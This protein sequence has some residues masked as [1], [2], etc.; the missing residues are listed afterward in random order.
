MPPRKKKTA[1][2]AAQAASKKKSSTVDLSKAHEERVRSALKGLGIGGASSAAA[3]SALVPP[4]GDVG[5]AGAQAGISAAEAIQR[6]AS[7]YQALQGQGFHSGDIEDALEQL[8]LATLSEEAALD[9][10]LLHLEPARLPRRYADQ[11]RHAAAGGAVDVKLRAERKGR[12]ADGGADGEERLA[13]ELTRAEQQRQREQDEQKREAAQQEEA[14]RRREQQEME[15][16]EKTDRRAWIMQ[17]MDNS[18][19]EEGSQAGSDQGSE[20]GSVVEDWEVWGDPREVERRRAERK[21]SQLPRDTR[22]LLIAEELTQAKDEAVRAK[23]AKDK[24]RQRALGELIRQL[25][26]EMDQLGITE[27]D[28]PT[29]PQQNT[30]ALAPGAAVP[31]QG[32]NDGQHEDGA[33]QDWQAG[34]AAGEA[35]AGSEAPD[36]SAL[37]PPEGAKGAEVEGAAGIGSDSGSDF[38]LGLFDEDFASALEPSEAA[39]QRQRR[40]AAPA[41]A[42]PV[43]PWGATAGP[44]SAG[45]GG[46]GSK[47]GGKKGDGGAARQAAPEAQQPKALLQQLCQ[48]SGWP[49]PRYERLEQGG[50]RLEGGGYRYCV[51][52]E[53]AASRGPRRKGQQAQQGPR[54]FRLLEEDDGWER[55]EEAQNAAAARA[56][57]DLGAELPPGGPFEGPLWQVLPPAFQGLWQQWEE[58]RLRA[59]QDDGA[60]R[61]AEADEAARLAFAEALVSRRQAE[62]AGGEGRAQPGGG[63]AGGLGAAASEGGADSWAEQLRKELAAESQRDEQQAQREGAA[64]QAEQ[65]RW[66]ESEE[67]ARWVQDRAKLPVVAIQQPLVQALAEHDVVV[68]SGET[69]SGK[70]TQVPQYI[71]EDAVLRGEG[72]AC[73]IV[74]TQPRRIAAISVAERVAAERGEAGPGQPG[75]RVGYHVRLD[76]AQTSATR[77]LFCTTG[78]LL[79]RL[80]GDPALRSVSHVLVD[81]VHERTLQGDFLMALLRDLVSVRRAAGRPLK[82][83]LMSAT[84]DSSL[85]ADYFAGPGGAPCPVLHAEGRTFPVEQL[86]LEDVYELTG[87]RLDADSPAALRPNHDRRAQQRVAKTAGASKQTLVRSGWGDAEADVGVLN[88][89]YQEDHYDR[90]SAHTRRNLARLDEDRIDYDLL[91]DLV[92]HID[93]EKEEGAVLVFLPGMGEITALHERLAGSR[94]FRGN[95]HWLVPLHSTVSPGEQ[96]QAF[97]RPPAGV[98]KIVLATNIAETS[99]TIEDVV[100]VVDS[101]KLKERRYDA[102]RGMSLLVEDWVSAASARQRRGR[103]G[104]VRPGVCY[105]LYTR[106]RLEHRMRRYQAPEMVRVPLE[107]LV[108]QIHLLR[109]GRAAPFLARVLQPPPDKSVTG[110]VRTLQE[111]GALTAE[112]ELTPLGHHLAQLPVDAR[113]GKLLLLAASLGCLSPALTMAAC[114]SYKSPF[115]TSQANQ[116]AA[117]RARRG[118]AS[119]TSGSVAAGQQSDHL[120]MVAAFD[121]WL[122]A[123]REGGPQGGRQHSRKHFLSEATLDMLADMRQQFA[124]MLVDIGFVDRHGRSGDSQGGAADGGRRV[125][126]GSTHKAWFDDQATPWNRYASFPAVVKAVLFAALN[127]NVAVMDEEAA[128][129]KRPGWHDGTGEVH[130]HPSSLNHPLETQHF[131]RPFI[132]YL[133][134]VRTSKSFLRECTTI[135]PMAILLFG[136]SLRVVHEGGYVVVGDWIRIRAPAQTAVLVKQLRQALEGLLQEKVRRPRVRLEEVGGP[137]IQSIVDL[138][139]H[140]EAAQQWSR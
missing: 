29:P 68:V 13:G 51:M 11:S 96:R 102:G 83:V 107:E 94:R 58:D 76:A 62:L 19:S 32:S 67:G 89:H 71:L 63:S 50:M 93:S 115:S 113:V 84:L 2:A 56:L 138:L 126:R 31:L 26:L 73:S 123:R 110:A 30:P 80:A 119:A 41:G 104:R 70:T 16:R 120:L 69:G 24:D 136:G 47:K 12:G 3:T 81:E 99:L 75:C 118:L 14:R 86:C 5:A 135:S 105:G 66:Q 43:Q 72:G 112:E 7:A 44:T 36:C 20:G 122:A 121:G 129:G 1:Q 79:R 77:L 134:K 140:E 128:P 100:Y 59:E 98:R 125:S 90:Y 49:A 39:G 15:E 38:G 21:R 139:N 53:P 55:I 109:L 42:P 131:H 8:P 60:D 91:E 132:T 27:A 52:V 88:P 35:K 85:F 106:H 23:L 117:D 22:I 40:G 28:F 25:K 108:L 95:A 82:V 48:R 78:I 124:S 114:L 17:Y 133:E 9:W 130:I 101:G 18:D 4:H 87:Y 103:A 46:G 97:K 45:G 64:M 137:V 111:V 116:D 61:A 34:G 57:F 54:T 10:L 65:R 6:V 127:P 33:Y 92:A 37:P 74:C